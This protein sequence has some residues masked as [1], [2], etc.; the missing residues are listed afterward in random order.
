MNNF[1]KYLT[2]SACL[3]LICPE[4]EGEWVPRVILSVYYYCLFE[5]ERQKVETAPTQLTLILSGQSATFVKH[6]TLF[7]CVYLYPAYD[8]S[9]TESHLQIL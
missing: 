8:S 3:V 5:I 7:V 1:F 9:T 6:Y 2:V 4:G